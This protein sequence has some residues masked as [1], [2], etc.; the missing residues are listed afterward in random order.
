MLVTDFCGLVAAMQFD[1]LRRREF[2][3]L[4]GGAAAWPM[5]AH[6]QQPGRVWRI[7][8]LSNSV[9]PPPAV[10]LNVLRESL[11]ERGY[12]EGQNTIIDVRW[13]RGQADPGVVTELLRNNVEVI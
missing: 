6:A 3:T 9:G 5:A 8:F 1:P 11:R 2:I 12:V 7:G 13:T 10:I 4:L